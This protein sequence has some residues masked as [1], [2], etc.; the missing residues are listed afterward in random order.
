MRI[1]AATSDRRGSARLSLEWIPSPSPG[2]KSRSSATKE[3]S[4]CPPQDDERAWSSP[5]SSSRA[6]GSSGKRR[7]RRRPRPPATDR[8]G[9]TR[10][11]APP[12]R[13][14]GKAGTYAARLCLSPSRLH[15]MGPEEWSSVAPPLAG[16]QRLFIPDSKPLAARGRTDESTH[17]LLSLLY[18]CFCFAFSL[19]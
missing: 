4:P 19:R 9:R 8:P 1:K 10:R 2:Y 7:R 11:P 6:G 18:F 3:G 12:S 14:G 16:R 13:E 15:A 5:R 17:P